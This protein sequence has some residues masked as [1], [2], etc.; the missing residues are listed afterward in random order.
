MHQLVS[1]LKMTIN[2]MQLSIDAR[3]EQIEELK[4]SK[5]T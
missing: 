2:D 1:D 3:N 5:T 4:Q